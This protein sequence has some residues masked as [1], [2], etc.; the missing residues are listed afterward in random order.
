[1]IAVGGKASF[2]DFEG[3]NYMINSDEAL[4]LNNLP[5][6]IEFKNLCDFTISLSWSDLAYTIAMPPST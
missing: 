2:P 3:N 4:D 1:M 6:S 5:N